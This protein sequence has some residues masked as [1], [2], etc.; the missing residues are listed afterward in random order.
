MIDLHTHILYDSDQGP[1]EIEESIKMIKRAYNAGFDGLVLAPKFVLNTKFTKTRTENKYKL[2]ELESYLDKEDLHIKLFLANELFCD[3]KMIKEIG[4]DTFTSINKSRYFLIETH[5]RQ[6]ALNDLKV[7]SVEL[8]A[9]GYI[10]ILTHP[11]QYACFQENPEQLLELKEK[12]FLTQLNLLSFIGV[13][14]EMAE[15][16]AKVLLENE[17]IDFLATEASCASAYDH[18][19]ESIDQIEGFVGAVELEKMLKINP[20]KIILNQNI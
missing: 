14:G 19:A 18:A 15:Y 4:Q 2:K 13:N 12:G 3:L 20:A 8:M 10:P 5:H 7:F 1:F 16:T 6:T 17:A 9:Q 11:E